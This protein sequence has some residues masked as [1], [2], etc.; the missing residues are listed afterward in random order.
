M[1]RLND[2]I[3]ETISIMATAGKNNQQ[4]GYIIT[5]RKSFHDQKEGKKHKFQHHNKSFK[6]TT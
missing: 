5:S 3:K 4:Q 2:N 6:M 1:L